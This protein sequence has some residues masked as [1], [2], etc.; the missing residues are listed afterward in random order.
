MLKHRAKPHPETCEKCPNRYSSQGCPCWIGERAGFMK[1]NVQTGE[2]AFVTGCFYQVIP[3]L[4]VEVIKA[5]NRP[6][7]AAESTRNEIVAGFHKVAAAIVSSTP[8]LVPP[9]QTLVIENESAD[10]E[11]R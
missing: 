8:Q 9:P 5:S 6:A 4:M 2:E 10:G 3:W 7:A 1:T 11:R